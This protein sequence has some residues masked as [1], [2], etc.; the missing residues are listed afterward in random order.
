[1]SSLFNQRHFVWIANN[2]GTIVKVSILLALVAALFINPNIVLAEPSMG[3]SVG[4][5]AK[6]ILLP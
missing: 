3:G 4:K 5:A 2:F 1:M 6:E